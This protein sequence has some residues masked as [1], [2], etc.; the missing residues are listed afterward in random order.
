MACP[1]L[2][3][4]GGAMRCSANFPQPAAWRAGR[5]PAGSAAG[6]IVAVIGPI[7]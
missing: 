4:I 5:F 1:I 6:R 2:L 3:R 7:G